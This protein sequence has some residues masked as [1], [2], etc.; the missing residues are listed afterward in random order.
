[1]SAV[2]KLKELDS[3]LTVSQAAGIL[4]LHPKFFRREY[5]NKGKVSVISLGK[6]AKGDRIE[7]HEI[8]RIIE[9]GRITR[10]CTNEEI[11][12][13]L[14]SRREALS[15]SDPLGLPA[16]GRLKSLNGKCGNR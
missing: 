6:G 13:T 16:S 4:S 7:R 2:Y 14:N 1:M 3:L 9:G 5:I 15:F 8:T 10:C 12:T 11:S